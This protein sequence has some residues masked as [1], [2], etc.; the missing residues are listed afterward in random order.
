MNLCLEIICFC[1]FLWK[2]NDNIIILKNYLFSEQILFI[3]KINNKN[4]YS[5]FFFNFK[6]CFLKAL[7]KL[8]NISCFCNFFVH[9]RFFIFLILFVFDYE[10]DKNLQI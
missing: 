3:F 8:R 9:K 6:A 5:V 10:T 4:I 2:I 1:F 7:I